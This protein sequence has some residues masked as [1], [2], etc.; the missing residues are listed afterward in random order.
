MQ[1]L[2][3]KLKED[4]KVA[5]KSGNSLKKELIKVVL[6]EIAIEE[7]RGKAGFLLNDE[8][9]MAVIKKEKNSQEIIK[10][11]YEKIQKEVP[12]D[13]LME[14]E[15]LNS[16]LPQQMTKEEIEAQVVE[17]IK[18][19]GSTSMKDMGQVMKSFNSKYSGKADGKTVS[20]IVKSKLNG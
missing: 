13:V 6:G 7:G 18:E 19:I 16:Y 3:E 4:L 8:G 20:E 17:T 14:I 2:K 1:T 12:A 15:I 9:V 11:E 5:L 10:A